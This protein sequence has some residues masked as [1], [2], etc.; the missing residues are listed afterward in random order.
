MENA[1][2]KLEDI[3]ALETQY[4]QR[5]GNIISIPEADSYWNDLQRRK[6]ETF[7]DKYGEAWLG[8]INRTKEHGDT[9]LVSFKGQKI[10]NFEYTFVI[11]K[12]DMRLLAMLQYHNRASQKMK[13]VAK[14]TDYIYSIDGKFLIWV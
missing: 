5:F 3:I 12:Y 4:I 13:D 14:L 2:F 7:H 11:P 10:F 8:E 9:W 1:E 6:I